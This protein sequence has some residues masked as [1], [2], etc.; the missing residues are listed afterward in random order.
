MKRPYGW[1]RTSARNAGGAS[2]PYGD[3]G[4]NAELFVGAD[5]D[6]IRAGRRNNRNPA[7]GA[8][9]ALRRTVA[10][11]SVFPAGGASGRARAVS[12]LPS[13]G[14]ASSTS[15]GENLHGIRPDGKSRPITPRFFAASNGLSV[16]ISA[17]TAPFSQK[18]GKN[19]NSMQP[20]NW[21]LI[22]D[23]VK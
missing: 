15:R 20:G 14:A 13:Q 12:P 6:E 19:A 8:V 22:F 2:R 11:S 9:F 23:L 18:N 1:G 17:K 21:F 4:Q 3:I 7:G 5:R 10:A 16:R